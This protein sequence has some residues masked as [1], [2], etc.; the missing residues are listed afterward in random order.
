MKYFV[1][2]FIKCLSEFKFS[3]DRYCL[4]ID[5]VVQAGEAARQVDSFKYKYSSSDVG[6]H[7]TGPRHKWLSTSTN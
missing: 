3:T 2:R 5:S 7:T 6:T 4:C 1:Q